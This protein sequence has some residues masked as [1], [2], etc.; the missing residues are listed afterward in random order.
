LNANY[1][2]NEGQIRTN[3]QDPNLVQQQVTDALYKQQTQY[4]DPQF[5]RTQ[6]QLANQLANQ[7]I[8]QGSEAYNNAMQ[9]ANANK[10]Q[11]YE[12]ARNSAIN[13]GVNAGSTLFQNQLAGANFGNQALGQQFNQGLAAQNAGNTALLNQFGMGLQGGNFANQ[14]FG[15]QFNQGMTAQQAGNTAQNQA[16]AHNLAN[17]TLNNQA[18]QQANAL[19]VQR[20]TVANMADAM[21]TQGLYGIGAGLVNSPNSANNLSSL[22]SFVKSGLGGLFGGSSPL[23]DWASGVTDP[24]TLNALGLGGGGLF[25]AASPWLGGAAAIDK[26]TGGGI[27]NAAK[28]LVSGAGDVVN[29][30]FGGVSDFFSD[31]SM[32]QNIERIGKLDNGLNLYKWDYKPE[33]KELAGYG[34]HTGVM[35]D[36]VEKIIPSAVKIHSSGHKM[37]N[38]GEIYGN[39]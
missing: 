28:N 35:A 10:Q 11:A 32:K 19:H 9:M 30:V 25:G 23:P 7:G 3:I 6:N 4:L 33:F 18:V 8:T 22:G 17:A 36:E 39:L 15:Q 1:G 26:L 21:K 31:R 20:E 24:E 34:T 5:E 2:N 16:F 27:G 37:V 12:S 29:D 14:A 13:A 38:Y